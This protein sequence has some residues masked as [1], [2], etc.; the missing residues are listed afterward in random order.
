MALMGHVVSRAIRER[1]RSK[2]GEEE[3]G[4]NTSGQYC[5]DFVSRIAGTSLAGLFTDC[6]YKYELVADQA[7]YTWY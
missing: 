1:M 5:Q 6:S 3:E 2:K 4:K 7:K